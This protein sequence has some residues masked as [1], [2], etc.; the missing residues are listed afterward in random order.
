MDFSVSSHS[1]CVNRCCS[2]YSGSAG[3]MS[4]LDSAKLLGNIYH[5]SSSGSIPAEFVECVAP[6][7]F[8]AGVRD[9]DSNHV[10]YR[11]RE[12]GTNSDRRLIDVMGIKKLVAIFTMYNEGAEVAAPICNDAL[13][14]TNLITVIT[15]RTDV[16]PLSVV[17]LSADHNAVRTSLD[18][19]RLARSDLH[20]RPSDR[21]LTGWNGGWTK[22]KT[23]IA[24]Q[25][26]KCIG[27]APLRWRSIAGIGRGRLVSGLK[28]P[29]LGRR[30]DR[31]NEPVSNAGHCK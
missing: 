26:Q 5:E 19:Y 21:R 28:P 16:M 29:Y 3:E 9:N 17:K 25:K 11:A 7:K 23:T 18:R 12:H 24:H 15:Y 6:G 22:P 10:G 2:H 1:Y 27:T 8:D 20:G 31:A 30:H 14:S 13:L 4:I